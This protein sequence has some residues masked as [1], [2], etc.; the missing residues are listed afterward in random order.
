M[1]KLTELD[2]IIFK[3][4][5]KRED[6]KD[7]EV[8]GGEALRNGAYAINTWVPEKQANEEIWSVILPDLLNNLFKKES[9]GNGY[10]RCRSLWR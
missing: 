9:D 10:S 5:F 2:K 8:R 4:S 1:L 7:R 3:Y 6:T